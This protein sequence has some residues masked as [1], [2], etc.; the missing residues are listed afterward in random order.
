MARTRKVGSPI[1]YS[2]AGLTGFVSVWA[3]TAINETITIPCQNSGTFNAVVDWG[4]GTPTST[5][6]AYNDAD[7]AHV[8]SA[9]GDHTI[10]ITGTFPNI[11]FNNG[12]EKTKIKKVTNLGAV[13]W[14]NLLYAFL[15]CSNLTEFTVG[16]A[17][18]SAVTRMDAM[19]YG[20]SGL[21]S[22]DLS[23]FSTSSVAGS[24]D[25]MFFSCSGLT[26]VDV[27]NFVT[28]S[29]TNMTRMFINCNALTSIVGVE[30]FDI[31]GLFATGGLTNFLTGGKMTT[32]QYDNLLVKWQAQD[33]FNGMTPS[34][35][36]SKYTGG[37]A[38][39]TARQDLIDIDGWSISDGGIA[40]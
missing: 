24:M 39:A 5:I 28:S 21:T 20:C 27:S 14:T 31:T 18:T 35:G 7:L 15:G 6:T 13:G 10:S 19:F 16:S 33:P 23:S 8:Y 4:D 9:I 1:G 29:V 30:D 3:T 2:S 37:G 40:P 17:D 25:N 38:A 11:Y 36:A 26:S 12:A 34:F 22:I 32:A